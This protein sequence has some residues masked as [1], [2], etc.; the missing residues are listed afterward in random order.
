MRTSGPS[1]VEE[2][3]GD[4]GGGDVGD[5]AGNSDLVSVFVESEPEVDGVQQVG[6]LSGSVEVNR[7]VDARDVP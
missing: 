1:E 4:C 3:V 5:G 2:S 7:R 6:T